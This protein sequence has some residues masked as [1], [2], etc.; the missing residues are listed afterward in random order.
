VVQVEDP[1]G[2]QWF[3]IADA[4]GMFVVLLP[5]P[6]I[7]GGFA[8]SPLVGGEA[9]LHT[10]VWDLR[11]SV[12]YSPI[13][14]ETLP[15]TEVPDYYSILSQTS[16]SIW[17]VGPEDGGAAEPDFFGTLEYGRALIVRTAGRSELLVSPEPTSP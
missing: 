14:L 8:G 5:Y 9:P 11:I 3:G 7:V 17:P 4:L 16:G 13:A 12:R 2:S 10:R 15:F 1:D 6:T